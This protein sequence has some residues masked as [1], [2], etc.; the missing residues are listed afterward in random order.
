MGRAEKGIGM[1]AVCNQTQ[2]PHVT[3][4]LDSK[5]ALVYQLDRKIPV[6]VIVH[7]SERER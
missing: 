4:F 1:R 2:S 3:Y 6:P 5:G 7:L